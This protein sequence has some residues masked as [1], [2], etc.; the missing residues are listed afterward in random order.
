MKRQKCPVSSSLLRCD[1]RTHLNCFVNHEDSLL[2]VS[3][4]GSN[5]SSVVYEHVRIDRR[6]AKNS[7]IMRYNL[8][9]LIRTHVCLMLMT[10]INTN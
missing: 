4:V 7:T 9:N 5:T 1:T 8:I 3:E 10:R 2:A 6:N